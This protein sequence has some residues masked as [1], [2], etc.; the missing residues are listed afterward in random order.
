M[1]SFDA[2]KITVEDTWVTVESEED[3]GVSERLEEGLD[4]GF[5]GLVRLCV[6][7][8]NE[9]LILSAR[10]RGSGWNATYHSVNWDSLDQSIV[11]DG[12]QISALGLAQLAE[13][14]D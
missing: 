7:V 4:G 10:L 2:I 9:S 6:V 5:K 14:I 1:F 8:H 11:K 3:K 13:V 12:S